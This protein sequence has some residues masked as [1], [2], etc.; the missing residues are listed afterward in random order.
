[1]GN[2]YLLQAR[3]MRRETESDKQKRSAVYG[4]AVEFFEKALSLDPKNAYAAQGVAIA[5]VEDRKD[6]K[7]A[8]TIF[9]KVRETVREPHVYVNLGHAFAELRQYSKAIEHYEIALTKEGKA[10]DPVILSCLGR[11][12]LN[13]GR[14]EKDI[15]AYSKALE[16][17]QQVSHPLTWATTQLGPLLTWSQYRLSRLH[18]TKYTISSMWPLCRFS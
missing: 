14:A 7:T 4:K 13:R 6:Y 16:C 8:L 11:T 12:W 2:L 18:Q 10:N 3:E 5:L 1:M 17:A 9:N 15:D